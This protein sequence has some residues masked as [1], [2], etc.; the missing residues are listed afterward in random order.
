MEE[1]KNLMPEEGEENKEAV[2]E[3]IVE[4]VTEAAEEVV[5]ETTE[6]TAEEK[7]KVVKDKKETEPKKSKGGVVA[8]VIAAIA[9]VA[10]I[11]VLA[12]MFFFKAPS[13]TEGT[14]NLISRGFATIKGDYVYHANFVDLK[15]YKT[16]IKTGDSEVVTEL[17]AAFIMNY[18]NDIYYMEVQVKAET[19]ES[20]LVLKKYV[21]GVNDIVI[22][23]DPEFGMPQ[24]SDGYIYYL[25]SVSEVYSGY[26][27]R[28][29]R[30]ELKE[31]ATS[32]LVCDVLCNT[33]YVNGKDLYYG[34][35][36]TTS[37]VK[38]TI[39]AAMTAVKEAPLAEG[40]T[41]KSAEIGAVDIIP[42]IVACPAIIDDTLYYI[43]SL[44]QYELRKFNLETMEDS[45]FNSGVFAGGLNIYGDYIYYYNISDFCVYRMNFDG[46]D[47][48]KMTAP[49]YGFMILSNDKF[50]SMEIS[51][52]GYQYIRVC[53]L[54]GNAI[55]SIT[56][57]EQ[58]EELL[59]T[60]DDTSG[61]AAEDAEGAETEAPEEGTEEAT[62]EITEE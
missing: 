24:I 37:F 18:K 6:E 52:E 42:T 26:S 45:S 7:V 15:M 39:D 58:Y 3:E 61:E 36:E 27:S 33:F 5:E 54:D 41:R 56:F 1:N 25:N 11:V 14:G 4:E 60:L 31:N 30:A 53:D 44:N 57:E 38:T 51:Q 62:G 55:R 47:V 29:Y 32:E 10:L 16:N 48:T 2:S 50:M 22:L 9:A 40:A 21:D 17:P 13:T 12:V 19:Q 59:A 8:A 28:L 46:S 20:E 34:D 23:S 35:V 43:D 49:G